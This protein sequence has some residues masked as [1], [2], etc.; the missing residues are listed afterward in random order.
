MLYVLSAGSFASAVDNVHALQSRMPESLRKAWPMVWEE[1]VM[2]WERYGYIACSGMRRLLFR[3]DED[4]K[5]HLT[6][7]KFEAKQGAQPAE[8][9]LNAG[10]A[11][12]ATKAAS[13]TA[14]DALAA[15][16]AADSG[17]AVGS[18]VDGDEAASAAELQEIE[19]VDAVDAVMDV[20][21]QASGAAAVKDQAES[22]LCAGAAAAAAGGVGGKVIEVTA[23][24]SVAVAQ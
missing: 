8:L 4:T 14:A 7:I 9:G 24:A 23:A 1:S 20:G 16:A 13:G 5:T 11:A 21:G 2:H 10:N 22:R 18:A 15:A 17:T 3:V 19:L 12:A 6:G